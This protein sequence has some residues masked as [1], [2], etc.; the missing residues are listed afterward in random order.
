MGNTNLSKRKSNHLILY[1]VILEQDLKKKTP[2]DDPRKEKSPVVS[3]FSVLNCNQ[4]SFF[5][6]NVTSK[7]A[8][9]NVPA[10]YEKLLSLSV[11]Y[12][13]K[14]YVMQTIILEYR[15]FFF[16]YFGDI[17]AIYRVYYQHVRAIIRRDIGAPL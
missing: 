12:C 9:R 5:T 4:A 7:A 3:Y 17:S 14:V 16:R 10:M 6:F 1:N 11:Q 8:D 15:F 13:A 2:F